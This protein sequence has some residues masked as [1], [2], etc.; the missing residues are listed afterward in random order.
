MSCRSSEALNHGIDIVNTL[1]YIVSMLTEY[2]LEGIQ[3]EWDSHKADSN[4]QKHGISFYTACEG[5]F[6]PFVQNAD[7][8]E[9]D[10]ESRE[11]I[12]GMTVAWKLL[13]VV[14]TRFETVKSFE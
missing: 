14:Y 12:I 5:F 8:E 6:D 11:A 9:V 2:E 13:Y 3:F 1:L 4:F 7:V 10:E